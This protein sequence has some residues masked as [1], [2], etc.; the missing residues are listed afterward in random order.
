LSIVYFDNKGVYV[1][2]NATKYR[3][4]VSKCTKG[5]VFMQDQPVLD[6]WPTIAKAGDKVKTR[7]VRHN[8]ELARVRVGE[9]EEIWSAHESYLK[10]L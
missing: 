5:K 6:R 3:P 10:R 9:I 8:R 7:S 4:E 1:M 2:V